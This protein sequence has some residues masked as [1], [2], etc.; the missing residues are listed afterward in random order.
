MNAIILNP[1]IE[2]WLLAS[3]TPL[4]NANAT[5]GWKTGAEWLVQDARRRE[6]GPR[7]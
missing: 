5:V 6:R 3:T 7:Q 4:P 2:R 1:E